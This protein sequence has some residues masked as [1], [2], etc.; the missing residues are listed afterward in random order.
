MRSK[1]ISR[2][3]FISGVAAVTGATILV[4]CTPVK[5]SI[6]LEEPQLNGSYLPDTKPQP[7]K[8]GRIMKVFIVYDSVY[9]NTKSIAEAMI[10]GIG[11][12][13]EPK[14]TKVQE[15]TVADLEG[16]DL[17]I[18]GAPNHGGT[19][20]EPLKNFFA[21]IPADGL[22]GVKA[23]AFDTSFVIEKQGAF[24]R[25]IMKIF[26]YAA[27]KIATIL[28]TKGAEILKSEVFYVLETEGPLKEGE[29][30]R[31]SLWAAALVSQVQT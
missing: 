10:N 22:K 15:A 4:A 18:V 23:A 1:K 9:G 17:L 31:A 8:E 3:E 19:F 29:I 20:T 24:V 21:S 26:G 28:G 30:E 13:R 12:N 2:R 6:S 14:I 27:P 5:N 11:S 25:V 16:I 7:D